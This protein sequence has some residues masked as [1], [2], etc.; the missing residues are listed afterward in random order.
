MYMHGSAAA[1]GNPGRPPLD[2]P[3]IFVKW[4]HLVA[5]LA[6]SFAVN[7]AATM[8]YIELRVRPVEQGMAEI[9]GELKGLRSDLQRAFIQLGIVEDRSSQA[10]K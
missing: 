9:A 4:K 2:A 10:R 7:W 5:V 8:A 6:A 3:E 1:S